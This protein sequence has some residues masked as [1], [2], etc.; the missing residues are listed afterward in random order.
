[1]WILW[2]KLL[3]TYSSCKKVSTPP[4]TATCQLDKIV[5]KIVAN[6]IM[7]NTSSFT[8]LKYSLCFH[9]CFTDWTLNFG[10]Y[11][12]MSVLL[13]HKLNSHSIPLKMAWQVEG[14]DSF[15][16]R[17]I[18][19]I[20][21]FIRQ[22]ELFWNVHNMVDASVLSLKIEQMMQK[23]LAILLG[24]KLRYWLQLQL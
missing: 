21:C 7:N 15:K 17:F 5:D 22:G 23:W 4:S 11:F 24:M 20:T 10:V 16:G 19:N 2:I 9:S 6:K 18:S 3:W 14:L 1:M 12:D 8:S 13:I